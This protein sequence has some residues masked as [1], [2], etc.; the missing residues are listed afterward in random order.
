MNTAI[1]RLFLFF[2]VLFALLVGW[3]SRW[4]VFEQDKLEQNALNQREV[5]EDQ[6]IPRGVIRAQI[7]RAHV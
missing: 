7:G 4:T 2:A 3:T 1:V 6:R 5:L